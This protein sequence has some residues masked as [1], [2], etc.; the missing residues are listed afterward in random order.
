MIRRDLSPPEVRAL[1][2]LIEKQ[3]TTPDQY[4]LSR[5]AVRLA[6]NQSTNRDPVVDYDEG[7]IRSALERLGRNG[8]VRFTSSQGSRTAKYRHIAGERLGVG[9]A[10]L[11]VLALLMLRGPQT[12][13]ELRGRSERLHHFAHTDEVEEVLLRLIDAGLAV[14]FERRPGQKEVRYAQLL[15]ADSTDAEDLPADA[16]PVA[17]DEPGDLP[18]PPAPDEPGDVPPPPP[19]P[20]AGG[21]EARVTALEAQ[22][23]DL[24]EK[25]S[26]LLED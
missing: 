14:R 1:G 16:P 24:R 7:T 23:A 22:V 21:L 4:P 19:P 6:C 20:S 11:A 26:D 5:N 12:P 2:C 13:G 15:S 18:R 8:L 25:L 10:E 3:R 9:D 17:P